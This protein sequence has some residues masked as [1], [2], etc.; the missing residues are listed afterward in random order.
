MSRM[1]RAA[2]RYSQELPTN[3][4]TKRT[5]HSLL[6][7]KIADNVT[8]FDNLYGTL[9]LGLYQTDGSGRIV[10]RAG[11][12]DSQVAAREIAGGTI[13]LLPE[14]RPALLASW[15]DALTSGAQ[16]SNRLTYLAP[17]GSVV[18]VQTTAGPV[19]NDHGDLIGFLVCNSDIT[20]EVVAREELAL[21]EDRNRLAIES[22][23]AGVWDLDVLENRCY[24]SPAFLQILGYE[25]NGIFTDIGY[26]KD[27]VHPEDVAVAKRAK[28][29]C[30]EGRRPG[31]HIELRMKTRDGKWGW[32]HCSGKVRRDDAGR[33]LR[34]VGTL[35]DASAQ[36]QHEQVLADSDRLLRETQ[37]IAG[38]GSYVLD[39]E[40]DQWSCSST[41]CE[42]LGI[43]ET[44][45]MTLLGH[46]EMVDP[47]YREKFID[48]YLAA[49]IGSKPFEMEYRTATTAGGIEHWVAE[50]CELKEDEAGRL[51]RMVGMIQ[52][53]T[54]RRA[55]EKAIR[56]LNDDL[57]RRVM[58]RTS[59]LAAAKKEIES[60]SYSVSHDLRAPLRH[61]NSFSAMLM[62]DLGS[63]LPEEARYYLD[64]IQS[65]SNKMGKLI[66]DLLTL[67]QVGRTKMK[68]ER[69]SMSQMAAEV[70][71]ML[72]E[73][74]EGCDAEFVIEDGVH[75]CGDSV[76][77]R[78]VL[79][80]LLGNAIKY[81]A[82]KKAHIEF[83]R[84]RVHGRSAF[85]VRDDGV[86][87]DM[88]YANNLFQPFQRL[89]G[90]EFEG[91][92]I[93][94]ATVRRIIE[95]HGGAIWAHG[96]ENE[97]ATFYFTLS[98]HSEADST[99]ADGNKA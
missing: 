67:T 24:F 23:H 51:C 10:Q 62:E 55:A 17:D 88:T 50:Y 19:H 44:T 69:F 48:S 64:R 60:F 52:D 29:E 2:A 84:T 92:G 74:E 81:S 5:S 57:D 9:Q 68:R 76:L 38:L 61:I 12:N 87:F 49:V 18:H 47:D 32:F 78:L 89:H 35:V 15:D 65:A 28:R 27:L 37:R 72:K 86:G 16:W 71:G 46:V 85:F 73:A 70:A 11:S 20:E 14:S 54:E 31:F 22:A 94:L 79:Q 30:V 59:Q 1:S 42:L 77:I 96:K 99:T 40:K 90:S 97:G 21:S 43:D 36:K 34:V 33:A 93:G 4:R 3:P 58:E 6:F 56:D 95:R 41:L 53:I 98:R 80:N 39:L 82:G 26:W 25:Q 75:A 45:P 13:L 8:I 63:A 66:D 91:T 7:P 83:G